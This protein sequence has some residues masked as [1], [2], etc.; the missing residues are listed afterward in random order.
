MSWLEIQVERR[1]TCRTGRIAIAESVARKKRLTP[2]SS[3]SLR[4]GTDIAEVTGREWHE[5]WFV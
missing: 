5:F 1:G 2:M 3:F 4:N